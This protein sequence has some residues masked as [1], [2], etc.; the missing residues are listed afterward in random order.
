M[1]L[2]LWIKIIVGSIGMAIAIT[3][4]IKD[5]ITRRKHGNV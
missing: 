2:A 4:Y 3:E 1:S 5:E